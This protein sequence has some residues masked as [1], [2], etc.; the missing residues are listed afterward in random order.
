[1]AGLKNE[2]ILECRIKYT[3]FTELNKLFREM[4]RQIEEGNEYFKKELNDG[5]LEF[6]LDYYAEFDYRV[7]TVDG[8]RS[9][10]IPSKMNSE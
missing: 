8:V 2:K 1:M 7:E 6:S 9:M 5:Y 10:I 3:S 4:K